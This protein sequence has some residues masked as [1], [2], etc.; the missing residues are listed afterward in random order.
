M[1]SIFHYILLTLALT[2]HAT[3]CR[4]RHFEGIFKDWNLKP[5]HTADYSPDCRYLGRP[6]CPGQLKAV[7][8]NDS[9]DEVPFEVPALGVY[10]CCNSDCSY[11][12][13]EG[14][15]EMLKSTSSVVG[16]WTTR[17]GAHY[18]VCIFWNYEELLIT[19]QNLYLTLK[20]RPL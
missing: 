5:A 20:L 4:N 7:V 10:E 16:F 2:A 3:R 1:F 12:C 11:W 8:Y 13:T 15:S 19:P 9:V 14:Q 17:K 18:G 6:A